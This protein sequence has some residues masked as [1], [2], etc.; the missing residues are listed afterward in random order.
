MP[1]FEPKAGGFDPG[2][3]ARIFGPDAGAGIGPDADAD[4]GPDASAR[5]RLSGG[6]GRSPA[7]GAAVN[8]RTRE[9]AEL[10]RIG[11]GKLQNYRGI[12]HYARLLMHGPGK[13]NKG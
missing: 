3:P 11:P 4:V 5:T 7:R 13:R 9:A 8:A 1:A 6:R 12:F 2:A 10:P